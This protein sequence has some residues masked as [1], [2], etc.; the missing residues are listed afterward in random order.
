[1][2]RNLKSVLRTYRRQGIKHMVDGDDV[3]HMS[4]LNDGACPILQQVST[5]EESVV[6]YSVS[7]H[8]VEEEEIGMASVALIRMNAGLRFGSFLI[9]DE[10]TIVFRSGIFTGRRTVGSKVLLF[11]LRMGAY[12]I[13]NHINGI[14]WCCSE[15]ISGREP[16]YG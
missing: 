6:I 1:M 5:S 13:N 11:H 8:T 14:E 4:I 12:M 7:P 10:G 2:N 15:P 3:T 16:M 9:D